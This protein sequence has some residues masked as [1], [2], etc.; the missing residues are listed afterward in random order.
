MTKEDL[1]F[2]FPHPADP[3]DRKRLSRLLA[4][5]K[6]GFDF[7]RPLKEERVVTV[8]GSHL[9]KERDLEY[10]QARNL[11]FQLAR[12]GITVLT[13]GG[14]GI[15]EAANR[16]AKE[17]GGRSFGITLEFPNVEQR[18]AYMA[19]SI[20]LHYLFVRR[21]LLAHAA[22]AYVFFPGGFGTLDEFFEIS[23]LISTRKLHHQ[24][25]VVLFGQDYW[26]SLR[27]WLEEV[28]MRR[29]RTV[30][31]KQFAFWRI[32]NDEKA[33]RKILTRISPALSPRH[34]SV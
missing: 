2:P 13:G 21:V 34:E 6:K 3:G 1:E 32:I 25:P 33:A 5:F 28:P 15:M 7:L 14:P 29:Y 26:G 27:R 23:T 10:R 20:E 31:K 19:K 4:E 16:G 17:G 11:A 8:F 22:Q 12:Q 30:L 18:N 9:K 24:I